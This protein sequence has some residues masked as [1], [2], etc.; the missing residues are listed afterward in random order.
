M[1][2]S[3]MFTLFIAT[4]V[5]LLKFSTAS[6]ASHVRLDNLDV[7]VDGTNVTL[8]LRNGDNGKQLIESPQRQAKRILLGCVTRPPTTRG[9]ARNLGIE[10]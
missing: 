8:T 7:V 6:T 2:S 4:F 10:V 3:I 1:H 5:V 9:E